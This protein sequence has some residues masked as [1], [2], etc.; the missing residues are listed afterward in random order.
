MK[1]LSKPRIGS[2]E[3][4]N[5]IKYLKGVRNE[6]VLNPV[7]ITAPMMLASLSGTFYTLPGQACSRDS[8]KLLN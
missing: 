7:T 2:A 4:A 3:F 8:R 1:S 6:Q 5:E